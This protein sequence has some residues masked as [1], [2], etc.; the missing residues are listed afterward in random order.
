[1]PGPPSCPDCGKASCA[2]AREEEEAR[3][4]FTLL[5]ALEEEEIF[6]EEERFTR[7]LREVKRGV[8]RR[9][10]VAED[11][12]RALAK[13]AHELAA[14]V[15]EHE[16]ERADGVATSLVSEVLEFPQRPL[17]VRI[18]SSP[19]VLVALGASALMAVI[20]AVLVLSS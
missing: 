9:D 2:C 4:T 8:V 16:L 10:F 5:P 13:R 18:L 20:V 14:L 15:G 3:A 12:S 7:L 11:E 1:M 6:E 17:W 19:R